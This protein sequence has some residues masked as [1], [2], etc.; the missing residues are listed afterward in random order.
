MPPEAIT[1][2]LLAS[3]MARSALRLGPARVPS[4]AMSVLM[5]AAMALLLRRRARSVASMLLS[6]TQ[7]RVATLPFLASIPMITRPGWRSAS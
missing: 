3:A 1:G 4:V 6:L 5:M 7:P 2:T